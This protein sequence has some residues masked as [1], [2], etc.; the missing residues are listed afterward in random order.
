MNCIHGDL[1]R[2]F[3]DGHV[4]NLRASAGLIMVNAPIFTGLKPPRL[5]SPGK[6]AGRLN[7][8]SLALPIFSQELP[9]HFVP[10]AFNS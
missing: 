9:D 1:P 7:S 5:Q 2:G 8:R 6:V 3:R 10:N 4:C